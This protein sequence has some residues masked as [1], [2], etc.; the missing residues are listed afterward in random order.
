VATARGINKSLFLLR[1]NITHLAPAVN[2]HGYIMR[3]LGEKLRTLR[4]HHNMTLIDLAE[5]LGYA[6]HGYLSLIET[7]K[8]KPSAEFVW[9][10]AQLFNISADQLLR[11]DLEV[12]AADTDGTP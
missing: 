4:K 3:R 1:T 6:S 2:W 11:D 5:A 12:D 8:K 10:V 7:G 9:K